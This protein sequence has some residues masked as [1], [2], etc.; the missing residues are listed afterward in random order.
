MP[1]NMDLLSL[2]WFCVKADARP[3]VFQLQLRSQLMARP[4]IKR[5]FVWFQLLAFDPTV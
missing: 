2:E 1:W 5:M 4:A 3:A